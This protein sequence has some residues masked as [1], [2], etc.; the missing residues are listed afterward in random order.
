MRKAVILAGGE[1]SRLRPLTF[2][3]PKAMIPLANTPIIEHVINALVAN[4]IRDITVVVGYRKEQV[5][6]HLNTLDLPISIAV[7]ERQLGAAHALQCVEGAINE[8]FILLPGDNFIDAASIARIRDET[9]AAMIREHPYPSNFGVVAVKDGYVWG[10]VEK[11]EYAPRFTVS[12]GIYCLTPDVFGY[13]DGIE[14]PEV[15]GE[16]IADG[17]RFKAVMAHEWHDA[18]YPWDLLTINPRIM[19][20]VSSVR[21]GTISPDVSIRGPVSIGKGTAIGPNT[22][23]IG[24]AIIGEDCDIGPNV[25]IMPNTSIGS[26][27]RIEPFTVVEKSIIMNDAAIG[28]HGRCADAV[29]GEGA[30]LADHVSVRSG[31]YLAE[32]DGKLIGGK[33]GAILGDRVAAAPFTVLHHCLVGNGASIEEGRVIRDRI[34]DNAVVK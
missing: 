26:R 27:V 19:K 6:R 25:V 34:P 14:I 20:R 29:I 18:I 7:Q 24:P 1:G 13:L 23:V 17:A 10:I 8:P 15:I 22:T 3:R 4:G 2:A 31:H 5:I 12:T 11:P 32:E 30:M 28:S 9:M 33:F 21:G 16:M